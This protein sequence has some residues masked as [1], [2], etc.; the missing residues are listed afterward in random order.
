MNKNCTARC[1]DIHIVNIFNLQMS[2]RVDSMQS[3]RVNLGKDTEVEAT[4]LFFQPR[5]LSAFDSY[6]QI[7]QWKIQE[8]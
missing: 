1:I 4:L 7:L 2:S 3:R 8:A 5:L 6:D